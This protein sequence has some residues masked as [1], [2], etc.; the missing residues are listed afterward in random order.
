MGYFLTD[1]FSE[2]LK[3]GRWNCLFAKLII[4]GLLLIAP[5]YNIC[6]LFFLRIFCF[7]KLDS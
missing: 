4:T 1:T 3:Q 7:A 2:F 5:G 6:F